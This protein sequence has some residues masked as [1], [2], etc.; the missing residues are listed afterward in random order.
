LGLVFGISDTREFDGTSVKVPTQRDWTASIG[1][2]PNVKENRKAVSWDTQTVCL[3]YFNN[4]GATMDSCLVPGS[5]YM[6]LT[7]KN[8][9]VVLT[10][11]KGNIA[12]FQWVNQGKNTKRIVLIRRH[13]VNFLL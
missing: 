4:A 13:L 12:N 10:S 7:F 9:A 5:P 3:Q 8:A 2:L 6:T 1:D 11:T